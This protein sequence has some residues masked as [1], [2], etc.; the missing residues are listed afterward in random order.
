MDSVTQ[1][2]PCTRTN[3]V[4]FDDEVEFAARQ[5]L[6][7]LARSRDRRPFFLVASMTHPNDPY[8]IPET[9]W[10][11]YRPEEIDLPRVGDLAGHEDPHSTRLRH[12]IGLNLA[13]IT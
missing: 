2:G 1:A 11:R 5:K 7:D 12:V 13:H 8:V 6:F 4:D 3:Q 10:T 9:Y